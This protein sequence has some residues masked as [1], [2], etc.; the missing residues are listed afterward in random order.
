MLSECYC[1]INHRYQLVLAG[2]VDPSLDL[3][4]RMR[5]ANLMKSLWIDRPPFH[6]LTL[7][8]HIHVGSANS[9]IANSPSAWSVA[10]SEFAEFGITN[11]QKIADNFVVLQV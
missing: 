4:F 8:R 10:K 11:P 2:I 3:L 5:F 9:A 1:P 7:P 6:I